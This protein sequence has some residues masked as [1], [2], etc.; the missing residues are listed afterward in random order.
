MDAAII[1]TAVIGSFR[2]GCLNDVFDR[3]IATF[4]SRSGGSCDVTLRTLSLG[5]RDSD[6]GLRSKEYDESTIKMAVVPRGS[7]YMSLFPGTYVREDALGICAA[8]CKLG[9][10]IELP[11]GDFY[12]VKGVRLHYHTPDDFAF[13]EVDLTKLPLHV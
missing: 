11:N 2:I 9:D 1:G 4:E 3:L 12:E 10:E 7:S 5:A 13:R 6:T 8:G